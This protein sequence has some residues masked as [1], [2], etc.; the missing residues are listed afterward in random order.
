[1]LFESS[2]FNFAMTSFEDERGKGGNRKH[3]NRCLVSKL[4]TCNIVAAFKYVS[5]VV[6]TEKWAL[7]FPIASEG[8][9][10]CW[11]EVCPVT[12]ISHTDSGRQAILCNLAQM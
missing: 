1:M 8:M 11:L 5:Q 7:F 4:T 9:R 3:K 2:L 10:L 6:I 12:V